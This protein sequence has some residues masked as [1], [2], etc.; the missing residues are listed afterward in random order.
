[1]RQT[2]QMGEKLFVNSPAIPCRCSKGSP[3]KRGPKIFVTVPRV[4]NYTF[5]HAGFSEVLPDWLGAHADALTFLGEVP[6]A[7]LRQTHGRG[8][9][10]EP[11]RAG[12]QPDLAGPRR[13]LW[14]YRLADAAAQATRLGQGRG[15]GSPGRRIQ[16]PPD[17]QARRQPPRVLRDHRPAALMPLPT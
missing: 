11:L 12:R 5:Y 3:R 9:L 13:P 1:M 2:R 8:H 17:A 16:R 15:G 10:G 4:S 14:H 7:L 6:K